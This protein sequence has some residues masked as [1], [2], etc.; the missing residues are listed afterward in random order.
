MSA[1][2]SVIETKGAAAT[3]LEDTLVAADLNWQVMEDKVQGVT[4]GLIMPR[5]KMLYRSDNQTPLGV[6]GEDYQPSDPREFLSSQFKLAEELGGKVV[7]A[8]WTER[9]A[10]AF[11]AIRLEENLT[12]PKNVRAK[13]DPIGVYLY[14]TDGWDGGSPRQS[15]AYLERLVCANGMTTQDLS[16]SLWVSHTANLEQ[17]YA[18]AWQ[19]FQA[20]VNRVTTNVREQYIALAKARLSDQEMKEF[21]GKLIPG[22]GTASENRRTQLMDLFNNGVGLGQHTKW[23][24]LNAVT[25][26]VTHHAVYRDTKIASAETSRFL[27]VVA[28]RNAL[29]ERAMNLLLH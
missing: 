3:T 25:E 6:V 22:E 16:S 29:A 4:C 8:G 17:R 12:F 19:K 28:G 20:E 14:S 27:G 7:R 13:G 2:L 24:A 9:R 10:R 5:K 11:C 15:S 23:D 21:L 26:Y 18:I 1:R